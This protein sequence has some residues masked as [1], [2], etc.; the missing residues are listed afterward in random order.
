MDLQ[1]ELDGMK[2]Q[3]SG[4]EQRAAFVEAAA[5]YSK[6]KGITRSAFRELGVDAKTLTEAGV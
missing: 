2:E 5:R 1:V 6:S 3:V 4:D